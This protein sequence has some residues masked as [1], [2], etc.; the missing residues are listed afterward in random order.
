MIAK[1]LTDNKNRTASNIRH[2]FSKSG[3]NLAET[4]AVSN[5]NFKY[6]G[7]VYIKLHGKTIEDLEEIIIESGADDYMKEGEE[8][9][10]IITD[11]ITLS[12]VVKFFREK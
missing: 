4:G 11:R 5:Y 10:K 6:V 3:G 12:S 7:V 2:H 8:F 9:A 1:T